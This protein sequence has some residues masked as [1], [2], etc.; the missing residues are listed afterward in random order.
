MMGNDT[1]ISRQ[2]KHTDLS[3]NKYTGHPYTKFKICNNREKACD[4]KLVKYS[5]VGLKVK[6]QYMHRYKTSRYEQF[7]SFNQLKIYAKRDPPNTKHI[8]MR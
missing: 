4:Y 8:L 3:K 2:R 7:L 5:Q 1:V 6:L